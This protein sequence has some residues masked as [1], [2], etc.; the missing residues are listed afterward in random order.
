[1]V[2][3]R[4]SWLSRVLLI[5][6]LVGLVVNVGLSYYIQSMKER[7]FALIPE[8]LRGN[9]F[10][11]AEGGVGCG[12]V[13][14]STYSTTFGLSNPL[15]GYFG[16]PALA[17]M[18]LVAFLARAKRTWWHSHFAQAT[19]LGMVLGSTFSIWLLYVQFVLLKTT[20]IYCLWVDAIMI[21]VT[22]IFAWLFRKELR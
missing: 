16:F 11:G 1:M 7:N 22:V 17:I 6:I 9:C 15:Y 20:C 5:L 12:A 19:L 13:Q 18:V 14:T 8:E 4:T 2:R 10:E 3:A 21:A